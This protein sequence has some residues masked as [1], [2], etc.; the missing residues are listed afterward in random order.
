MVLCAGAGYINNRF[1]LRINRMRKWGISCRF[2]QQ[3]LYRKNKNSAQSKI[4]E[5]SQ[6]KIFQ[7]WA[8]YG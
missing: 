3:G 5:V 1:L 8:R 6:V 4:T 2:S 7:M